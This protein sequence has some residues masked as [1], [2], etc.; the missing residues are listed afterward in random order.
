MLKATVCRHDE[1]AA[2]YNQLQ[3]A[4]GERNLMIRTMTWVC[5][6]CGEH[7]AETEQLKIVEESN[8]PQ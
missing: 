3:F 6:E 4:L 7:G 8:T 1:V 2:K 5:K